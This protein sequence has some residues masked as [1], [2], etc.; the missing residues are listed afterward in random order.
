MFYRLFLL[1]SAALILCSG[2]SEKTAPD[3]PTARAELTVR[4]YDTLKEK[5]YTEALAINDKL[6]ALD[7]NDADLMEMR[8]R[9]IGNIAAL[10]VQKYVDQGRLEKAYAYIRKERK[11]YPVMP[12]LRLL[13]E[14]VKNLMVLRDAA[15][16]LAE[17]STMPELTAA[18]EYIVP[19]AARYPAAKQLNA[20]I[21][22]RKAELKKMRDAAA[23][24]IEKSAAGKAPSAVKADKKEIRQKQ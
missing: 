22:L 9:I 11:N 15:E 16:K 10:N 19:L 2:C 13:E 3:P 4:L 12:R 14:E 5:R 24:A 18:L 17:A 23:T 1:F 21:A 7:P 8:D 6:L 20:D